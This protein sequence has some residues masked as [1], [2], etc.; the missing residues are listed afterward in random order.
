MTADLF[1][2][3]NARHGLVFA[4]NLTAEQVKMPGHWLGQ[5]SEHILEYEI[6]GGKNHP[7]C[8]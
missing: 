7:G 6:F 2:K 1:S 5:L 4:S 3:K 8:E